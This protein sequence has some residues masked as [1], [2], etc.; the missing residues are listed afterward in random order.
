MRSSLDI[1]KSVS[2]I[3]VERGIHECV[4]FA[5]GFGSSRTVVNNLYLLSLRLSG[6]VCSISQDG[7]HLF[8]ATLHRGVVL[9]GLVL[10]TLNVSSAVDATRRVWV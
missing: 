3:I 9:Q 8:G 10:G 5:G 6:I 7:H 1:I 4:S 2:V